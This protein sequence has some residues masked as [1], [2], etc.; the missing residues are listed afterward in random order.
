M[1]NYLLLIIF[2]II[3]Q[4]QADRVL[5]GATKD[6]DKL[7]SNFQKLEKS[8]VENRELRELHERY[9]FKY[10]KERVGDYSAIV[11]EDVDNIVLKESLVVLLQPI[12]KDIFTVSGVEDKVTG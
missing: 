10:S 7:D 11:I 5:F 9:S 6:S 1:R 2:L 8:L 12:F 4:L 3:S